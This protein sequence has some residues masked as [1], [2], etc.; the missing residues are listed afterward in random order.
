M[1]WLILL[2]IAFIAATI[3][4]GVWHLRHYTSIYKSDRF[5]G[6]SFLTGV[7]AL[8]LTIVVGLTHFGY[9]HD[10]ARCNRYAETAGKPTRMERYHLFGWDCYVLIGDTWTPNEF[11][12]T[13]TNDGADQ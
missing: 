1:I 4:A 7:A 11:L 5:L 9:E 12:R 10:V 3:A 8:I 2:D 6:L 13:E